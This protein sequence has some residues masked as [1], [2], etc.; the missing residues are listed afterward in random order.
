[1]ATWKITYNWKGNVPSGKYAQTLPTDSK[2]YINGEQYTVDDKFKDGTTVE[3]TDDFGNVNG[4]YTFHGWNHQTGETITSDLTIEGTWSFEPKTVDAHNVTYH[5]EGLPGE[6][7]Y[8]KDGNKVTP[9]E[10]KGHTSLVNN[11]PYTVDRSQ[12]NMVVYTHDQYGNV[13][14]KYTLGTWQD[15]ENGVMK[16]A[17]ITIEA[18]WTAEAVDVKT[19][20]I[21]YEWTGTTVPAGVN[22]P[23]DSR[24]YTNRQPYTV[25]SITL[26][27]DDRESGYD[28]R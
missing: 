19:W 27:Q 4:V 17:N 14:A 18:K 16:N 23:T 20:N 24:T 15:P 9:Q 21:T 2:T 13:N 26:G 10:P 28:R 3:T 1:M 11:Q 12:E 8:D 5:W 25:V 22:P 7:L 6:Q